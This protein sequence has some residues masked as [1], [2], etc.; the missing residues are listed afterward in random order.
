MPAEKN[1]LK[2]YL[3]KGGRLILS[4]EPKEKHGMESFL[5][6]YGLIFENNFILSQ[7]GVLYGSLAKA[8]GTIFDKNNPITKKLSA[9][10]SVFLI[11]LA[12]RS[13]AICF[14]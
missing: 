1:W 14:R 13:G 9:K 11:E 4:L 5:K 7:I 2:E 6:E 12:L 3:S 10:Q 8:L